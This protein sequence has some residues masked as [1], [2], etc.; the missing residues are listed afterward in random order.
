MNMERS[1]DFEENGLFQRKPLKDE[2]FE[3]LH[4]RV[5][6]GKYPPGEWLRQEEIASQLGVS[7]TPVREA[8]DLLVSAGIAERVPYRGVRVLQLTTQEILNSY[9][10]RLLLEST[11]ARAAAHNHTQAQ[12]EHLFAIVER[13]KDLLTL[14]DMSLQRQLNREFHLGLVAAGG[15]Q[16]MSKMYEMVTNSFPDWMLYEYMFRHPELLESSLKMEYLEH[17]AIVEAIAGSHAE[18]AA[19]QTL[20]HIL[21]LGRELVAFLGIQENILQLKEQELGPLCVE[22]Q[23]LKTYQPPA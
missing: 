6:A 16:L 19:E 3:I 7:Q 9:S 18:L 15:N 13:T 17:R 10:L 22:I 2:I 11:A 5:I 14:N 20:K 1:F 12:V 21:N 8:L 4:K 23:N